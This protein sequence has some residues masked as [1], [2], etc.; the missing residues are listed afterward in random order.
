MILLCFWP[1]VS[2]CTTIVHPL[3]QGP[4]QPP[5]QQPLLFSSEQTVDIRIHGYA[6]IASNELVSLVGYDEPAC[7]ATTFI[8]DNTSIVTPTEPTA[9]DN[10]EAR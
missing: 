5:T 9:G 8:A 1:V 7:S 3:F 2:T 6:L 4:S 10:T